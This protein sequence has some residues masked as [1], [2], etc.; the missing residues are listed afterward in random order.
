MGRPYNYEPAGFATL[1]DS[2][3]LCTSL[4]RDVLNVHFRRMITD[5]FIEEAWQT[6]LEHAATINCELEGSQAS[7][8][9]SDRLSVKGMGGIFIVHGMV[10]LAVLIYALYDN[11][12]PRRPDKQEPTPESKHSTDDENSDLDV[13]TAT[14]KPASP[15][16]DRVWTELQQQ[17]NELTSIVEQLSKLTTILEENQTLGSSATQ[18]GTNDQEKS[19]DDFEKLEKAVEERLCGRKFSPEW[20]GW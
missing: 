16:N 6:Q 14:F 19:S 15:S 3:V 2:G 12:R 9:K 4:L 18:N 10:T 13:V 20:E 17:R 11:F 8:E 1:A 7:N 5:G